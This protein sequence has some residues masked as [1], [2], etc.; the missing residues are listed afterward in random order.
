MTSPEVKEAM[1]IVANVVNAVVKV[2]YV[3]DAAPNALNKFIC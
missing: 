3:A 1:V 2:V